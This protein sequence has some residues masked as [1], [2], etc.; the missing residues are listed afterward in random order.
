MADRVIERLFMREDQRFGC[1]KQV[2]IEDG[3]FFQNKED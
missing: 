1:K 2:Q 3:I